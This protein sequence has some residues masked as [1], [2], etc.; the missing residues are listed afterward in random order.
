MNIKKSIEKFMKLRLPLIYH[1]LIFLPKIKRRMQKE[2]QALKYGTSFSD[3]PHSSIFF[4]SI[5]KCA[6][7]YVGDLVQ[8][9]CEEAGMA[10]LRFDGYMVSIPNGYDLNPYIDSDRAAMV[11]KATAHMYSAGTYRQVPNIDQYLVVLHLRDPR[12]A[13]TSLYFS[14]AYSHQIVSEKIIERRA[15]ALEQGIDQYVLEQ[16]KVYQRAYSDYLKYLHAK[17]FVHFS[18]YE[19]MILDFDHWLETLIKVLDLE[20]STIAIENIIRKHKEQ[21]PA[22]GDVFAQR[23]TVTPGD[24]KDKLQPETIQALNEMFKDILPAF[25]YNV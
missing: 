16:A 12:D 4:F 20:D 11:F 1:R 19:D 10:R 2:D 3:S 14:T 25:G 15:T 22:S 23:R 24:H 8:H 5:Q 6:T 13:L 7:Q 21:K 17:E 18:R 9:L